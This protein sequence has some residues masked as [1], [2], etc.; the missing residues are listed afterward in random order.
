MKPSA[1]T[2]KPSEVVSK[3][4]AATQNSLKSVITS[5]TLPDSLFHTFQTVV[6]SYLVSL[7]LALNMNS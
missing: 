5:A 3:L 4:L 2:Q 6:N 7:L 1:T